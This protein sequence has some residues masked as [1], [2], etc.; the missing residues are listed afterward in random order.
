MATPNDAPN[1]DS[2]SNHAWQ[3]W[4]SF[5]RI[6]AALGIPVVL[7]VGTW[8]IQAGVSQ[9]S[10]S[11]D[12]VTLALSILEKP[13]DNVE[14]QHSKGLRTWAVDLVNKAAPVQLDNLTADQ[15]INGTLRLPST[16]DLPPSD[17]FD[18]PL[19][20]EISEPII[21]PDNNVSAQY[22]H[23]GVLS[24]QDL[25]SKHIQECTTGLPR[26]IGLVFSPLVGGDHHLMVIFNS[27]MFELVDVIPKIGGVISGGIVLRNPHQLPSEA[28]SSIKF[29]DDGNLEITTLSGKIEKYDLLAERITQ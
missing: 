5:S 9:Q 8:I 4:E 3:K 12:Y 1:A 2:G 15:L 17:A 23:S 29:S 6:F 28:I 20:G 22:N 27:M 10:V 11:K 25:H 26:P 7:A 16:N 13:A 14:A 24:V 21:S 19:K 18:F